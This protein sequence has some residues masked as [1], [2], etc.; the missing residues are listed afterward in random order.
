LGSEY[1]PSCLHNTIQG[2]GVRAARIPEEIEKGA[3]TPKTDVDLIRERL[4]IAAQFA[5]ESLP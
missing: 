2:R 3:A 5:R 4:R 1:V